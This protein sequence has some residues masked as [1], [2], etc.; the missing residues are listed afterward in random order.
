VLIYGK[1]NFIMLL[2]L[3]KKT[4]EKHKRIKRIQNAFQAIK[5][6]CN[7]LKLKNSE[8]LNHVKTLKQTP[9]IS[10][11]LSTDLDDFENQILLCNKRINQ[12]ENQLG[13]SNDAETWKQFLGFA[14]F[15]QS[16]LK[17]QWLKLYKTHETEIKNL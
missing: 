9:N 17:E 12:F 1:G 6:T 10:D 7:S 15:E 3:I 4:T 8:L 13:T 5:N 2:T 14:K 16:K 11:A